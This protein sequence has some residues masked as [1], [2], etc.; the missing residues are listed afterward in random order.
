MELPAGSLTHMHENKTITRTLFK[1]ASHLQCAERM[2]A[3]VMRG[4]IKRVPLDDNRSAHFG[5]ILDYISE[6]NLE[7]DYLD[8]EHMV[9]IY[10]KHTPNL[11]LFEGENLISLLPPGA[12]S[13]V[14]PPSKLY[15]GTLRKVADSSMKQGLRSLKYP[16]LILTENESAAA[17]RARK[18]VKYDAPN[19]DTPVIIEVDAA[20]AYAAGTE[21]FQG[22]R[23]GL[24]ATAEVSRK[25]LTV[26]E[27]MP[28]FKND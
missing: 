13:K 23:D 9:E 20:A 26:H 12:G 6:E 7:L 24:Y 15:F 1:S 17:Y 28:D 21:F 19:S 16:Q 11:F 14:E 5:T 10:L 18:F 27:L 22:D 2:V 8:Y 3:S 25:F 4:E